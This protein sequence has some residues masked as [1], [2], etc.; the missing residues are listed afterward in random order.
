LSSGVAQYYD[1]GI[2]QTL[3]YDKAPG[4]LS[5]AVYTRVTLVLNTSRAT[6]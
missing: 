5:T 4:W 1:C 3:L 6:L 2:I